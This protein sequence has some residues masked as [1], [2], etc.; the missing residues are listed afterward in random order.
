MLTKQSFLEAE[1]QPSFF[2][3]RK[4]FELQCVNLW[5]LE[6]VYRY[7]DEHPDLDKIEALGKFIKMMDNYAC[8]ARTERT[9]TMY[10]ISKSYAEYILDCHLSEFAIN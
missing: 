6:E 4:N 8:M 2:D 5:T 3:R 10:S 9:K 7:F 1:N